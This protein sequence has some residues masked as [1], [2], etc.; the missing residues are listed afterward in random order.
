MANSRVR[1][2]VVLLS[3]YQHPVQAAVWVILHLQVCEGQRHLETFGGLDL[4]GTVDIIRVGVRV[5]RGRQGAKQ[6]LHCVTTLHTIW[7]KERRL[8]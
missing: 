3:I 2:K 4:P 6:S 5:A 8:S 1:Y 7:N